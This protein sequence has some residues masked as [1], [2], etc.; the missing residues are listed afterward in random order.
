MM[1]FTIEIELNM[2]SSANMNHRHIFI[3]FSNEIER[4]V[5]RNELQHW[6]NAVKIP[7]K[8]LQIFIL[9]SVRTLYCEMNKL[10]CKN[11]CFFF[12]LIFLGVWWPKSDHDLSH[13]VLTSVV[14]VKNLYAF[15]CICLY[16]GCGYHKYK[17]FIISNFHFGLARRGT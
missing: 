4:W 1:A 11:L 17:N 16:F 6:N 10:Y 13:A 15:V 5:L 8:L 2:E 7:S 9:Y 3:K 12:S 14:S